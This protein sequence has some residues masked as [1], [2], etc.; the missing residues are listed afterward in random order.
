MVFFLVPQGKLRESQDLGLSA[1]FRQRRS[2]LSG[3]S[4][5]GD[6]AVKENIPKAPLVPVPPQR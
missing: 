5:R 6:A 3:K 2:G 1:A 4:G